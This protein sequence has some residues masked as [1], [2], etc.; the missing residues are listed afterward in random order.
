M[1]EKTITLSGATLDY[2]DVGSGPAVVFVHGVYITGAV[3]DDVVD[4]LS[5][6]HRC[7]V[8]T[9]PLGAHAHE[10]P[11]GTDLSVAATARRVPEL[12]EALDLRDVTIV[13]N[14]SGGGITLTSLA[15]GHPG[16]SRIGALVL[17]NCD[18]FDHF[19][20]PSFKPMVKLCR[21]SGSIGTG[22]MRFFASGAGK[23]LF[24]KQVCSTQPSDER[25]DAILGA[26]R[27]SA[28]SRR[29][30]VQVTASM[31]PSLTLDAVPALEAL[32]A[33]VHVVWGDADKVFPKGDGERIAKT[34]RNG[35]YV[36]VPGS[37]TYVMVDAPDALAQAIR[38]A[39]S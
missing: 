38:A 30:A 24:F 29:D 25:I 34:A 27:T 14:D 13:A 5:S 17:T 2:R 4:R 11:A 20:P 19:P 31:K 1:S 3:W 39:T 37:G 23:K 8:P 33:P 6:T 16:L 22:L 18:S 28:R 32:E 10:M 26:F 35:T 15:T 21:L 7:I 36:P 9:W 12:L